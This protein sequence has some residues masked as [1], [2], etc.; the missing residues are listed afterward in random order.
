MDVAETSWEDYDHYGLLLLEQ[1]RSRIGEALNSNKKENGMARRRFLFCASRSVPFFKKS[2][3]VA[4]SLVLYFHTP[5]VTDKNLPCP[6]A[7]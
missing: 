2:Q 6:L 1:R 7:S 4:L 5:N 3:K